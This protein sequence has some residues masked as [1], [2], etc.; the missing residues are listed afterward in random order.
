MVTSRDIMTRNVVTVQE[1]TPIYKAIELLAEI[2][3]TGMPVVDENQNLCG[4][5][6]EQDVMHLFYDESSFILANQ[7]ELKKT[8]KD[9]MTTPAV[10]FDENESVLNVCQ[11]LKDRS[12]RRVPITSKGRLVGV[13]SRQDIIR[14]VIQQRRYNNGR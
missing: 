14:Y 11:C 13:V 1:S 7:E 5:I 4:I 9:F 12:F 6:T 3:I 10:F 2:D 8:V